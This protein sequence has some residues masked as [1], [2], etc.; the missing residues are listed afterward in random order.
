MIQQYEKIARPRRLP[1]E[2]AEKLAG[3]I[4][5]GVLKPGGK[6]PTEHD[7]SLA[8][9]VARTVV[10]EAIAQLKYE[11]LIQSKQGVGAFI[12]DP[13]QKSVFRIGSSCFKKRKE[14]AMVLQL[15]TSNLAAAAALAATNRTHNDLQ[16]M[17][18]LHDKIIKSPIPSSYELAEDILD[19]SRSFYLSIAKASGNIHFLDIIRMI[20]SR[21]N[22]HLRSVAV[23]NIMATDIT[24]IH[25]EL[26]CIHEN[27]IHS[28]QEGS[29][30]A[31]RDHFEKS[32]ERLLAR[33]DEKDV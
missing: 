24:L 8:F 3:D 2:I 5:S 21:L 9:G 18:E 13:N 28:N 22:E 29:R 12:S 19:R 1:D 11:G 20:N 7:L 32:T 6:L 26:T 16:L 25:N 27:I 4:N 17:A 30:L 15:Q 14:L 23:K 31:T 33:A 10:R